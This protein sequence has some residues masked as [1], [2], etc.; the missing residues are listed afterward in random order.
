MLTSALIK[1]AT[2]KFKKK[3]QTN[4]EIQSLKQDIY[5]NLIV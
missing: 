4:I 5:Q 3:K 2:I 1:M